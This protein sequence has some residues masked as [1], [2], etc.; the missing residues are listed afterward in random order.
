[1]R[2]RDVALAL[3]PALAKIDDEEPTAALGAE[4]RADMLDWARRRGPPGGTLHRAFTVCSPN[5]FC[6]CFT[7]KCRRFLQNIAASAQ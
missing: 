6:W 5:V 3:L 7:V 1:M 2:Y 4:E